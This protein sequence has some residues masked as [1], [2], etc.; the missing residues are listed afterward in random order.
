MASDGGRA[1][2]SMNSNNARDM[3]RR[4][5]REM[6]LAERTHIRKETMTSVFVIELQYEIVDSE[7]EV[8]PCRTFTTGYHV[9][10]AISA[11][12]KG[13]PWIGE[14]PIAHTIIHERTEP[15]VYKII[16]ARVDPTLDT[17]TEYLQATG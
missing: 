9:S 12:K 4:E 14:T 8:L 6:K 1:L 15:K 10:T 3:A 11:W 16:G 17:L 2:F 13:H 5:L 7:G